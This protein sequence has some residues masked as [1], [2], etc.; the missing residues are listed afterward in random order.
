MKPDL[1]SGSPLWQT[2]FVSFAAVLLLFEIVRGWRLGL[3]RQLVRVGAL[4]AAYS[5]AIFGGHLVVPLLRPL[6]KLPD[7]VISALGGAI[8]A[9][10]IYSVITAL[11]RVVFKRTGQQES[12]IV[13]LIYGATGAVVGI[14][15]GT[16]L[17]WILV[18]GIRSLGSIA[19]AQVSASAPGNVQRFEEPRRQRSDSTRRTA[20]AVADQNSFA[21]SL[22][23]LKKSIELG[24]VG[25]IVK[26]SDVVPGG[27]Y[28]TLEKT[29]EVFSQ[30]NRTQRFLTYPG[31]RELADNP[32]ILALRADP[33]VAD[34]LR[35]GRLL[36]LLQDDRLIEVANDPE[37]A[38]QLK[39]FD[40]KGA[41][42][43]ALG[44]SSAVET[45]R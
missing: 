33:A 13:R 2:V 44:R 23:R 40:F 14:F 36:D 22:A 18:I 7:F 5:V 24:S 1:I 26:Q 21:A 31:V 30:P 27:I 15:F 19:E 10:V 42:E 9:L 20:V 28:Q 6:L 4:G 16:F 17:L 32:K 12:G 43:Y 8:L 38:S 34:M 3:P 11:G 25:N 45:S 39:R 35:D 29:G 41:L 37:L